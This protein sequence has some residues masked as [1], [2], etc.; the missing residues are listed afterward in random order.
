MP[1]SSPQKP[2]GIVGIGWVSTSSPCSPTTEFPASSNA[3]TAA[4]RYL[5]GISPSQTGVIVLP[6]T[7]AEHTSVPPEI[8]DSSASGV[9]DS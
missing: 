1:S 8:G 2:I 9:T 6:P 4:P 5:V 3:S 7:N